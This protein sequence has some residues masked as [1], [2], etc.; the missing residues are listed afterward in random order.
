MVLCTLLVTPTGRCPEARREV[1]IQ[2]VLPGS[3]SSEAD[4]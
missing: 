4:V 3:P 1:A 2:P